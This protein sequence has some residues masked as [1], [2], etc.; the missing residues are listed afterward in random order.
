MKE[1][2]V[3]GAGSNHYIVLQL[4]ETRRAVP[5]EGRSEVLAEAAGRKLT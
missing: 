1:S 4:V 2:V 3:A 5:G